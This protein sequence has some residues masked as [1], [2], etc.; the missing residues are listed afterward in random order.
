MRAIRTRACLATAASALLALCVA[1]P[2]QADHHLVKIRQIHPSLGMF[3]GEWVELQMPVGGENLVGG[4]V[5]RTFDPGGGQ[6]SLYVIPGNAANGQSQ[7]TIL[8][9][10]LFTPAGVSADFVAPAGA[11]E[12]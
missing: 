7:R 11:L 9:S 1:A 2:A 12:M 8:I 4:K 5:I 6:F 3:G 10:N